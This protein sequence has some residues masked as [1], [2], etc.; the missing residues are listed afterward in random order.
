MEPVYLRSFGVFIIASLEDDIFSERL[1]KID[2][3]NRAGGSSGGLV[4][5][6]RS[7]A[8]ARQIQPE[9]RYA[10]EVADIARQKRH[11]VLKGG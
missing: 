4:R 10:R 5:G 7:Q 2:L 3:L 11:V 6:G 1:H 9:V 8:S